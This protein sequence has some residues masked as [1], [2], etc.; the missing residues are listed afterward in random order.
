MERGRLKPSGAP[1]A[2][3]GILLGLADCRDASNPASNPPA[4][5]NVSN[6]ELPAAPVASSRTRVALVGTS[7]TD[8]AYVSLTPGTVPTG[9][10]GIVRR[11]GDASSIGV[12]VTDGGFDPVP[13]VAQAGDSIDVVVVDAS[14][15]TAF[16]G[17]ARVPLKKSPVVLRTDPSSGKRDVPLNASLVIVFSEPIDPATLTTATVQLMKGA[18]A[19][20]G[21]VRFV[22]A[23]DIVAAFD[24]AAPLDPLADYQL[25]ITTGIQDR[26]GQPLGAETDVT[27]TTGTAVLAA[28]ASVTI[29]SAPDCLFVRV[30]TMAQ[31]VAIPR[32]ANF[33]VIA[34]LPATWSTTDPSVATVS[35]LGLLKALAPGS[36]TLT[37]VV[38][39]VAGS[40]DAFVSP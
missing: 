11:V 10:R 33:A 32:D 34:G 19:V 14:G 28:V 13:V 7:G 6:A 36:A 18:I 15:R 4:G 31:L 27:F 40:K 12:V 26:D 2:L 37:A 1:V 39:G 25:V 35:G 16:H 29:V 8:V 21:A 20:P 24:P 5:L 23:S 17:G 38:G 22:D 9:N 3:L 30:G